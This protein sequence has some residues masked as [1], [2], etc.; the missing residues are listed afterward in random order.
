V[1]LPGAGGPP[2]PDSTAPG[3]PGPTP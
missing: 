3:A 2:D 1:C